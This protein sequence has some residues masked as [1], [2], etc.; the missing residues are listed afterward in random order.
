MASSLIK[1][2][3]SSAVVISTRNRLDELRKA[4]T[5]ALHQT[6]KP[7]VVVMDDCSNDGT[8]NA[9]TREFTQVRV[10]RS[11]AATGYISQRNRAAR[12]VSAPV[13]FSIDDDAVFS[14]PYVVEQTL[15]EFDHPRIGAVAIPFV[16]VHRGPN[17]LHKPPNKGGVYTIYSF[18]GTSHAVRRD[19][20]LALGGYDEILVHQ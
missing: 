12:L 7:D 14:S 6:A 8:A 5:S 9:I 11:E 1:A 19:V 18:I 10:I 16:D 13:I 15:V 3:S 17:V 2:G 20:F 4:V